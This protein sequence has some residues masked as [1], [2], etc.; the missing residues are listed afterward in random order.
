VEGD[1]LIEARNVHV[2]IGSNVLLKDISLSVNPGEVVAVVG[3]NG[4]GKSTLRKALC[5]DTPLSGGEVFMN[6]RTLSQWTLME[7]AQVRAVMP[8]NSTL[9]FPFAVI[10]VVLMGRTPHLK[11]AEGVHDYEI[12]RAA[13]EAVEARHLEERLYPTLSGGERQRVQLARGLAQVWERR[14]ERDR[15]LILDE[16][17]SNLDL[18]HQHSTLAIARRFARNGVGVLVILHDLNL[19]A[20]YADRIMMLKDG[21]LIA[22]GPPIDVLTPEAIHETFAIRVIVTKHPA[23]ECPLVIPTPYVASLKE[24]AG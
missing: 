3:P 2:A 12:A 15:Y 19:A 24:Q 1:S 22:S 6:G 11:G 21:L 17:T 9:N 7:R 14:V 5:G 20:Q 23:L 13:L 4:A 8:Q 16:P 18:A 10:E